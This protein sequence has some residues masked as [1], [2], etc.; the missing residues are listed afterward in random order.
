VDHYRNS[1]T[2]GG[3]RGVIYWQ[4]CAKSRDGAPEVNLQLSTEERLEQRSITGHAG[5]YDWQFFAQRVRGEVAEDQTTPEQIVTAIRVME[6]IS[7][8]ERGGEK[9]CIKNT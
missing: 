2:I 9:V 1:L 6:A 7:E 5:D 3:T 4:T 8:A